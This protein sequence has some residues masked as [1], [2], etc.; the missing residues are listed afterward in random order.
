MGQARN[1]TLDIAKA[2]CICLMVIGHSGCPEYI[3]NFVYMFHMPCFFFISGWLLK[4]KYI[5][6]LKEGI[7]KKA[8]GTYW[9][10]VKWSI[11]FLAF[12]NIFAFL[13][14]Y[15]NNYTLHEFG[16][17]S[18]RI[19]TLTGSESLLG[20]FWF[21]ISLFW[22]SIITLTVFHFLNK[23]HKL[24]TRMMLFTIACI[25][26][27]ASN[28]HFIT[29]KIPQQFHEQTLSATAFFMMAYLLNTLK[30]EKYFSLKIAGLFFI[31]PIILA[32]FVH[33][34]MIE[35]RGFYVIP[36]FIVALL[37]TIG[38]FCIS[39]GLNKCKLADIFVYIGNKTLYILIFHFLAF[40]LVS[41]IYIKY[42]NL[43]FEYLSQFPTLKETP[44][45]LWII[46]SLIGITI[47][48]IIWET[49]QL[50]NFKHF[51]IIKE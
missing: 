18:L 32:I 6:N 35:C 24:S 23:W 2:I 17:K 34:G 29:F 40:K 43:P 31:I 9:P 51:K 47:P 33:W 1:K 7:I 13:N 25:L 5:S 48:L 39:A 14:I 49:F 8:K 4:P 30:F 45:F 46:Y 50:K 16:I 22:A 26:I 41:F 38:V 44:S 19:L 3:S 28:I 12:H 20:G 10:F 27:V 36:Y 42:N 11:I 21:L 15:D 37:G